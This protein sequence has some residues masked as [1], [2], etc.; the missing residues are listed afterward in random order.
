MDDGRS[1]RKARTEHEQ[2]ATICPVPDLARFGG[3]RCFFLAALPG[4]MSQVKKA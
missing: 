1:A 4:L 2:Q 3:F